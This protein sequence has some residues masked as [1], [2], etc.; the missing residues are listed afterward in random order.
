MRA[1]GGRFTHVHRVQWVIAW[2]WLGIEHLVRGAIAT[3]TRKKGVSPKHK[4]RMNRGQRIRI[5][6]PAPQSKQLVLGFSNS[7]FGPN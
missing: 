4:K 7:D 6:N 3:P 2:Q 1:G 5:F